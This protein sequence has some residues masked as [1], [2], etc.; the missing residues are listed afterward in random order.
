M[1]RI[2]RNILFLFPPEGIHY[3]SMNCLKMLCAI[4][5]L[6]KGIHRLFRPA[7]HD[8][9][10][11]EVC[12]LAFSNPVGLGAGF[13]KNAKYLRLLFPSREMRN[14]ACSGFPKTKP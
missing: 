8:N 7:Q 5:F 13:D 14:P 6:K 2:L 3:F 10:A 9:L 1:Y 11:V 4:P 12:R